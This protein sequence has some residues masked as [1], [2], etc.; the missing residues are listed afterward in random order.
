MFAVDPTA[1]VTGVASESATWPGYQEA[2][3]ACP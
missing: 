1:T 2:A 3:S